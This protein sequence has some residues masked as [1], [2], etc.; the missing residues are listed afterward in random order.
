MELR[1]MTSRLEE[2]QSMVIKLQRSIKEFQN[3]I[4]VES[5]LMLIIEYNEYYNDFILAEKSTGD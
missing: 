5:N 4:Q 2:E 3:R 1:N